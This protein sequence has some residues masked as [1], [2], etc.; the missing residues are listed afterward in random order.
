M[1]HRLLFF[2]ELLSRQIEFHCLKW[3]LTFFR[4]GTNGCQPL[5]S[6]WQWHNWK[7]SN[8]FLYMRANAVFE[9]A[10]DVHRGPNTI[11]HCRA[12]LTKWRSLYFNGEIERQILILND[13]FQTQVPRLSR[14][15]GKCYLSNSGFTLEP[16]H[17]QHWLLPILN[18]VL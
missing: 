14:S 12:Q 16:I 7:K 2:T 17:V 1:L 15:Q 18:G 11:A 10:L 13:I 8:Q 6:T 4:E 3:I 5:Q 9:W